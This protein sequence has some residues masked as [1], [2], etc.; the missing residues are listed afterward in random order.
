MFFSNSC[1]KTRNGLLQTQ[2][3]FCNDVSICL[4]VIYVLHVTMLQC[5]KKF[6]RL[7]YYYLIVMKNNTYGCKKYSTLISIIFCLVYI[8]YSA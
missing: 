5:Y 7:E 6:H 8:S 3:A 4:L 2:E 1:Y